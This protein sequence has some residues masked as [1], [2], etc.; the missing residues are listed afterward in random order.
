MPTT[1]LNLTDLDNRIREYEHRFQTTSLEMLTDECV[2]SRVSEDILL[3]WEAY[4]RQRA[5]LREESLDRRSTYLSHLR[6][7]KKPSKRT[8]ESD[9]LAFAA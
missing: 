9:E 6:T 3:K 1:V 8:H 4:V 5:Y 2:R 7:K